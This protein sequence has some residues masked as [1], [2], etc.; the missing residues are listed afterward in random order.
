MFPAK[1]VFTILAVALFLRLFIWPPEPIHIEEVKH[2]S[3]G[4]TYVC[5][6]ESHSD[7]LTAKIDEQ[8]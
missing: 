8:E 2:S 1:I 3:S 5:I 6:Y 7:F 4:V